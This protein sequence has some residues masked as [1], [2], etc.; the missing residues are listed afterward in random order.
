[1]FIIPKKHSK[2][3]EFGKHQ[4]KLKILWFFISICY[5]Y[6]PGLF[7]VWLQKTLAK[8]DLPKVI[9]HSWITKLI[10]NGIPVNVVSKI[11]GHATTDITL[12]IYTHYAKDIDNS[13]EV[14]EKIFAKKAF[15]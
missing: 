13:K 14:L 2:S 3:K 9:R 8:V 15:I 5:G 1:M 10:S 6:I 11:A 12:K 4:Q 7:R